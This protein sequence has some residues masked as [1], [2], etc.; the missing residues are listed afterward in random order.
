LLKRA[1]KQLGKSLLIITG[2]GYGVIKALDALHPYFPSN[3][4]L[5]D[6]RDRKQ[7]A[8]DAPPSGDSAKSEIPKASPARPDTPKPASPNVS[9]IDTP[10]AI[11]RLDSLE[12]KLI[13]MEKCLE[14]L[15][16]SAERTAPRAHWRNTEHFVARTELNLAMEQLSGGLQTDIERR[17][18]VQN[19]SVQS[20][21]AMIIR[22]D[23]LLEQVI[24]ILESANVHA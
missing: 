21:R 2:V 1:L 19:R 10:E 11:R 18:E 9:E 16:A 5:A 4:P 23:E 3:P 13:R 24:E 15:V 22:T 17:F 6:A 14:T 7:A 12:E 8:A 20:L